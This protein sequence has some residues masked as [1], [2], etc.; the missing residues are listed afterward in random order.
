M[1]IGIKI[2]L[3]LCIV[4]NMPNSPKLNSEM[5]LT[6][7]IVQI[8]Y[9]TYNRLYYTKITLPAL[10]DSSN[11]ISFQVRIVDNG[12][13]DG[14]VE[15]LKS[16]NHPRIEKIIYNT[17]N[18]GLVKPTKQFWKE[19]NAN[20]VGKIDNDILVPNEWIDNLVNAHLKIPKLGVCG[21]SHFHREDYNKIVV[22]QKVEDINGVF[23]RRQP[24]IGGNYLLKRNTPIQYDYYRQSWKF[25]KKRRFHGFT[26]YQKILSDKGLI[27]GYLC[28]KN[29]NL[30]SWKHIDD[31]RNKD[32]R[33]DSI[34]SNRLTNEN[35]IKWY[36]QDAKNLLEKY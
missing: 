15:Y 1:E 6:N 16:L 2:L 4:K 33:L 35:I 29:K 24:W 12:S 27:H 32:Y 3:R 7:P 20:F 22:S 30:F 31:P 17:K 34:Y 10:L 28:D 18:K 25:L 11:D 36:K 14:T 23:V 19:S 26:K 13:T 21:Y 5:D 8:I 9:L